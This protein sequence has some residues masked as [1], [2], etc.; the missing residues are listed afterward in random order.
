[1][2]AAYFISLR[3]LLTLGTSC[4]VDLVQ[5][6][7]FAWERETSKAFDTCWD[8]WE[9]FGFRRTSNGQF[10]LWT[11]AMCYSKIKDQACGRESVAG[12]LKSPA[13]SECLEQNVPL[14]KGPT[15]NLDWS[16]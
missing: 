6:E 7:G 16:S 9:R 2:I 8:Q 1:M 5:A 11:L 15:L 10:S 13:V 12:K 4:G 14:E 3:H